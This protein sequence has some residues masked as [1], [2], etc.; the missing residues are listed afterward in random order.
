MDLNK[1]SIE[2]KGFLWPWLYF[3]T[4]LAAAGLL[5]YYM[6]EALPRKGFDFHDAGYYLYNAW[7]L[8][9]PGVHVDMLNPLTPSVIN[10]GFMLLGV[11]EHYTFYIIYQVSV[12]M[13]LAILATGVWRVTGGLFLFPALPLLG[14]GGSF[15]TILSYQNAPPYVLALSGGA[16]FLAESSPD[17]SWRAKAW[18]FVSGMAL[19]LSAMVNMSLAPAS[20]LLALLCYLLNKRHY[21]KHFLVAYCAVMAILLVSVM[22]MLAG[23]QQATVRAHSVGVAI[24]RLPW[25]IAYMAH[26]GVVALTARIV[27]VKVAGISTSSVKALFGAAFIPAVTWFCIKGSKDAGVS[28]LFGGYDPLYPLDIVGYCGIAWFSAALAMYSGKIRTDSML[29][30]LGSGALI[31]AATQSALTTNPIFYQWGYYSGLLLIISYAMLWP[32]D[33]IGDGTWQKLNLLPYASR[34]GL[35]VAMG[36]IIWFGISS[37]SVTAYNHPAP[38]SPGTDAVLDTPKLRG[39]VTTRQNKNLV[40]DMY[41]EYY[42]AGCQDRPLLAL[43]RI[44]LVYYLFEKEAVLD[45]SNV[46]M[47]TYDEME[48]STLSLVRGERPLCVVFNDDY[49]L[50]ETGVRHTLKVYNAWIW[51]DVM[52]EEFDIKMKRLVRELDE[53]MP[54]K[55]R[56]T[57]GR[58][59]YIYAR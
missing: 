16:L 28:P 43:P 31:Y 24:S 7:S 5:G 1:D 37:Q 6:I 2:N 39:I 9:A 44:P 13:A 59:Y 35:V 36:Y 50:I 53:T 33:D 52:V 8:A 11:R 58:N 15:I 12:T 55:K 45:I 20:A 41:R 56:I 25:L 22:V 21:S 32:P 49:M 27:L 23:P 17:G 48:G 14:I 46:S 29:A 51:E 10:A 19:G 30:T 26:I 42:A 38:Y 54:V 47:F 4:A 34:A 3:V 40:E 18:G 57:E